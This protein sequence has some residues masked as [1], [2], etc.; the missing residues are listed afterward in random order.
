MAYV[1]QVKHRETGEFYIGSKYAIGATPEN[2]KEYLGSSKGKTERCSRYR[3]LLTNEKHLLDKV[4]IGV[5]DTKQ[6]ALALEIE[7]HSK[8]FDNPLCL[9]GAKQTSNRFSASFTGE[10]HHMFGKVHS[11]EAKEKMRLAKLGKSRGKH[12][13][14]H[15]EKIKLAQVGRKFT[16]EH[17]AKLSLAK[18]GKPRGKDPRVNCP[19][20]FKEIS[21]RTKSVYHFDNCKY[22]EVIC[23]Q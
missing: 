7:M 12:T 20:C 15:V 18:L 3:Y 16:E 6:D 21:A 4:I 13:P 17:K 23:Q 22:K 11:D 9:N 19:H 10:E 5:F 8:L 2:T 1:Y 14:E